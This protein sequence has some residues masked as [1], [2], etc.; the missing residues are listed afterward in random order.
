MSRAY[1]VLNDDATAANDAKRIP[2]GEIRSVEGSPFD[3]RTLRPIGLMHEGSRAAYDHNYVISRTRAATPQLMARAIGPDS[4]TELQVFSTE[5]G[6]QLYD[7]SYLGVPS[8][9]SIAHEPEPMPGSVWSHNC[10]RIR[11]TSRNSAMRPCAPV[12]PI[13]RSPTIASAQPDTAQ[14]VSGDR[15]SGSARRAGSGL[16]SPWS[17]RHDQDRR[18]FDGGRSVR[19]SRRASNGHRAAP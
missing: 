6:V 19:R 13:G 2:T 15:P 10:S 18:H 3:F 9:R 16:H 7:G 1:D 4:R 12:K 11:P 8:S 5:P 17:R 14:L